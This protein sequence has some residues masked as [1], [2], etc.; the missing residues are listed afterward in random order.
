MVRS[1][2]EVASASELPMNV[3]TT[4]ILREA[5]AAT[6]MPRLDPPVR[7][8]IQPF[9]VPNGGS[10]FLGF[11]VGVWSHQT[12]AKHVA[13][14][15]AGRPLAEPVVRETCADEYLSKIEELVENLRG[16]IRAKPAH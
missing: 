5:Q 11:D 16:Q 14:R 8:A 15:D 4:T 1:V 10:P 6:K 2:I 12:V 3:A 9:R 13:A 7:A